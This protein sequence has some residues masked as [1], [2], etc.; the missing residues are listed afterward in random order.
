[1]SDHQL[2]IADENVRAILGWDGTLLYTSGVPYF[3]WTFFDASFPINNAIA[4]Y[5]NIDVSA[6]GTGLTSLGCYLEDGSQNCFEACADPTMFFADLATLWN[7]LTIGVAAQSAQDYSVNVTYA[8]AD[9]VL[10]IGDL[11]A[12]NG[13]SILEQLFDCYAASCADPTFFSCAYYGIPDIHS[14]SSVYSGDEGLFHC[15]DGAPVTPNADLAGP[16][17][18]MALLWLSSRCLCRPNT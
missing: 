9:Q 2:V 15:C 16:G 11:E 5:L 17:V 18:S 8:D 14:L 1:M 10:K 6:A 4:Y 3:W 13:S 12:W 7:C